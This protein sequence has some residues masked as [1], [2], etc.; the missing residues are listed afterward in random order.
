MKSSW[1]RKQ[2]M[3]FVC[4]SSTNTT[5]CAAFRIPRESGYGWA[6]P[7]AK[8]MATATSTNPQ[9]CLEV[10]SSDD[11]P[12]QGCTPSSAGTS[13]RLCTSIRCCGNGT[14][15]FR[16]DLFCLGSCVSAMPHPESTT[17]RNATQPL[18]TTIH[19]ACGKAPRRAEGQFRERVRVGF[20][21]LFAQ[22]PGKK[23]KKKTVHGY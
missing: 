1:N 2:W 9:N 13:G 11:P 14:S 6:R 7:L 10:F 8:R 17:R 3:V 5:R 23:K 4:L 20:R 22:S 18:E 15:G 21:C 16:F 12:V 19:K